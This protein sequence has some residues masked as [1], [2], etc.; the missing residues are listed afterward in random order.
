[1]IICVL[2]L[3]T[4][5]AQLQSST[6]NNDLMLFAPKIVSSFTTKLITY[7]M[8]QIKDTNITVVITYN[9]QLQIIDFQD[10]SDP[11]LLTQLTV[12]SVINDLKL[13]ENQKYL[14]LSCLSDGLKILDI[15]N[16][17]DI[18]NVSTFKYASWV[19]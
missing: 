16:L 5:H 2:S 10:F 11:K 19:V 15:S 7:D 12:A 8:V 6:N 4:I 14:F 1:M 18:R 17:T 13:S 3:L 9:G